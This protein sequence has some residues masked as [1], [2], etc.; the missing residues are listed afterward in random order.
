MAGGTACVAH[1]ERGR[2]DIGDGGV[3]ELPAG[4]ATSY[5]SG[6]RRAPGPSPS[7]GFVRR[8][9]VR[10]SHGDIKQTQI[11]GERGKL[12]KHIGLIRSPAR[13]PGGKVD[14]G[15]VV[16]KHIARELQTIHE[17]CRRVVDAS[18]R[19]V[20]A[21]CSVSVMATAGVVPA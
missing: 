4:T 17:V 10:R 12:R 20:S 9:S 3:A 15:H 1:A 7:Q 8:R 11:R 5:S 13:S 6:G 19:S 2:S 14:I 18:C 16:V 21:N